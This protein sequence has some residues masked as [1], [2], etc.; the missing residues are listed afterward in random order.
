MEQSWNQSDWN[1]ILPFFHGRSTPAVHQQIW[2]AWHEQDTVPFMPIG[3]T[4]NQ[5]ILEAGSPQTVD[6]R[7]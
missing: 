4:E 3:V 6:F 2:G 5:R 7:W 1:L